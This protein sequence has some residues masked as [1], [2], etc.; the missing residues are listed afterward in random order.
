MPSAFASI[1]AENIL[2]LAICFARQVPAKSCRV[3]FH[4]EMIKVIPLERLPSLVPLVV[5][6]TGSARLKAGWNAPKWITRSPAI[7]CRQ[8]QGK[9]KRKYIPH[10]YAFLISI[11]SINQSLAN[12]T[13]PKDFT[14]VD[15]CAYADG[16]N[17]TVSA[18][19]AYVSQF[20]VIA[21]MLCF[22]FYSSFVNSLILGG[23]NGALYVWRKC[24][25]TNAAMIIKGGVTCLQ[26]RGERVYCGGVRGLIKVSLCLFWRYVLH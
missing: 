16:A 17:S 12:V 10:S 8:N 20:D 7:E 5:S 11:Q 15:F 21:G 18:G 24:V 26:I 19:N 3:V 1:S 6:S 22:D 2:V 25:L 14:C 4:L 13:A 23:S 9:L